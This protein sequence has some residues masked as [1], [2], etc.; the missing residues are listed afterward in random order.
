LTYER[1][2]LE[3]GVVEHK[4]FV[5]GIGDVADRDVKGGRD[6]QKLVAIRHR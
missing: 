1:S 6:H 4:K 5:R 3:P 2:A